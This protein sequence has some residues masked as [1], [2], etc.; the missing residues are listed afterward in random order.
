MRYDVPEIPG[1]TVEVE[2]TPAD[3]EGWYHLTMECSL[4]G[5]AS[6]L[7]LC[8]TKDLKVTPVT[9]KSGDTEIVVFPTIHFSNPTVQEI[10]NLLQNAHASAIA[11]AEAHLDENEL[12]L[13]SSYAIPG[14]PMVRASGLVQLYDALTVVDAM[15]KLD[16]T[17]SPVT[18]SEPA[19]EVAAILRAID[20]QLSV[21]E[22]THGSK[23]S[24]GD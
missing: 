12:Q 7:R 1:M 2:V 24:N 14:T 9:K 3:E 5:M 15:K 16:S 11:Y 19:A 6:V 23:T 20:Q 8:D 21:K 17:D 13:F 22:A 18:F 10:Y 4:V